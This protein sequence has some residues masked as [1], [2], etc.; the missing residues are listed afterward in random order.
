MTIFVAFPFG[1]FCK[2]EKSVV[3]SVAGTTTSPSM[4]AEPALQRVTWIPAQ[5]DGTGLP[6]NYAP[7]S[8]RR[9]S[10]VVAARFSPVAGFTRCVNYFTLKGSRLAYVAV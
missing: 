9:A 3:P 10:I 4:M 5:R 2:T 8:G 1:S 6:L 7:K